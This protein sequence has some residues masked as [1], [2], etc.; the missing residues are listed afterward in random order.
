MSGIEKRSSYKGFAILYDLSK[1]NFVNSILGAAL[2]KCGYQNTS[3]NPKNNP[4]EPYFP[5]A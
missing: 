3:F 1:K 5:F 4:P 2:Y